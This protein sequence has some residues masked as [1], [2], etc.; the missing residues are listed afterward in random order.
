MAADS[1][2]FRLTSPHMATCAAS[3]LAHMRG[4][5]SWTMGA[6]SG[7]TAPT[8]V[9][10]VVLLRSPG[11]IASLA[12][13]WKWLPFADMRRQR[14]NCERVLQSKYLWPER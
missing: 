1:R 10:T 14:S 4:Y 3:A 12:A 6:P 5:A 7:G 9:A 8:S 13:D 11:D 2:R